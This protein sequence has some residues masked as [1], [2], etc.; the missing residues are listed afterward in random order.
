MGSTRLPGKVLKQVLGIPLLQFQINRVKKSKLVNQI[1]IATSKKELDEPIVELCDKLAVSC[2][3]GSEENV[4]ERYYEAANLYKAD[5]VVRLTADCPIVD[6][7]VIDNVIQYFLDHSMSYDYV[8]NTLKRTYP[9]GMDTELLTIDVL[10]A[11]YTEATLDEDHEHVTP[12]IYKNPGRFR[13]ANVSYKE[14]QSH[15]RWT[16]DTIEDF[17]LIK[18]II[19]SFYPLKQNFSLEYCLQLLGKNPEWFLINQ[20][21][22]QKKGE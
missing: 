7:T 3:Q 21:I 1:V 4:L 22:K 6:P 11:A 18:K 10:S 15:Q 19:E 12:F 9:R 16:V 13:L 17:T 8:S 20:H 5:I 14:D 2:Y